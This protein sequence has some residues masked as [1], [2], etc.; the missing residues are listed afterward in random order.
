VIYILIAQKTTSCPIIV[1]YD[2]FGHH[3]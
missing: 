1:V 2:A 3:Q